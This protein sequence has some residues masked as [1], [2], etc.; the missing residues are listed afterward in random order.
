MIPTSMKKVPLQPFLKYPPCV[1]DWSFAK[2][3]ENYPKY[4][5]M[6][7]KVHAFFPLF[8]LSPACMPTGSF[9]SQH[10]CSLC[11]PGRKEGGKEDKKE[12]WH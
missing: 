3:P 10:V 4:T 2:H 11:K 1:N 8:I 6:C 5:N 9:P 7:K 12:E